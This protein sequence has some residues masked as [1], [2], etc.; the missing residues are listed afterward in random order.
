MWSAFLRGAGV[1]EKSKL[2]QNP[3]KTLITETSWELA[4]YLDITFEPFK[5]LA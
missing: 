4:C 3:D 5:G 2:P 1:M